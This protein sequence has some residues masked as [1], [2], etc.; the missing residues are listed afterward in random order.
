MEVENTLLNY[1]YNN[2]TKSFVE[3]ID[4]NIF[5][6]EFLNYFNDPYIIQLLRDALTTGK[7]IGAPSGFGRAVITTDADPVVIKMIDICGDY[8]N[9]SAFKKGLCDMAKAGDIIYYIKNTTYNKTI[10]LA[11]NHI[12]ELIMSL[13]LSSEKIQKYTP[14]FVKTYGVQYLNDKESPHYFQVMEPL[15][16]FY[17]SINSD[18][19]IRW[20][21]FQIMWALSKTQE[22]LRYTHFDLHGDNIMARRLSSDGSVLS[23]YELDN[24]NYIY[25]RGNFDTVVIDY[26]FN[27]METSKSIITGRS[28]FKAG[29]DDRADWFDY[30]NFNPF[31]DMF[32]A[33]YSVLFIVPRKLLYE[34]SK[35]MD[36]NKR[37]ALLDVGM[38]LLRDFFR[39][40]KNDDPLSYINDNDILLNYWRPKPENFYTLQNIPL[41]P[42]ELLKLYTDNMPVS[43][44]KS[45]EQIAEA[46]KTSMIKIKRNK[47]RSKK[48]DFVKKFTGVDGIQR[49][50]F[51]PKV[52]NASRMD[53][54][55]YPIRSS[56]LSAQQMSD[57]FI[58]IRSFNEN[59]IIFHVSLID[60]EVLL[61]NGYKWEFDC[62]R[63]VIQDILRNPLIKAGMVINS[64][65]FRIRDNF[66]PI[67]YFK[68]P[69]LTLTNPIPPVYKDFY[70]LIIVDGNTNMLSIAS[71]D[72]LES[73]KIN[74][75]LQFSDKTQYVSSGPIIVD[76]YGQF[77]EKN[78]TA[79]FSCRQPTS[80]AELDMNVFSDG[81]S[82]CNK[83]LPG[84]FKHGCQ[85]NPRSAIFITDDNKVGLVYVEGRNERGAGATF[86]D[87]AE[88]CKKM[89]AK[90]AINLDG[91]RSSQ[92]LWRDE[93][94]PV[95]NQ[96]NPYHNFVYPVGATI[97]LI[98]R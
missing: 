94:V 2:S 55:Q 78:C 68:T 36:E 54:T 39:L 23:I 60:Q 24:G 71:S 83:I 65:F 69:D 64:S 34:Q 4:T 63:T 38:A 88:I 10:V 82:N 40:N 12:A 57:G 76:D 21:S 33:I 46:S 85:N 15:I 92:L 58:Q 52:P 86:Q 1:I 18:I 25:Y 56:N 43:D 89:G 96:L 67:G 50:N 48:I 41:T 81:L 72:E 61:D 47:K 42:V 45:P 28:L 27:R 13:L 37:I 26:G 6:K 87:L 32:T 75:V 73:Q 79:I 17:D 98:K 90:R 11:P 14:N 5:K 9:A 53:T 44:I 95:I 3:A 30:Y 20:Y 8:V 91:G 49:V 62:C 35:N 51:Y 77:S 19:D 93:N 80:N 16:S 59:N 7:Q 29:K 84:E 70:G 31:V 22:L 74:G 97:G 66:E